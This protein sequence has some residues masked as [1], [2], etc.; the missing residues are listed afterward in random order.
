MQYNKV[1]I[2]SRAHNLIKQPREESRYN[3]FIYRKPQQGEKCL[4]TKWGERMDNLP[5]CDQGIIPKEWNTDSQALKFN[6]AVV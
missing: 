5:I 1:H 4:M 6:F 3:D 2:K